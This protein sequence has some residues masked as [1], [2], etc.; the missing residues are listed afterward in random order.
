VVDGQLLTAARIVHGGTVD[1]S[2]SQT[3]IE[4]L[5]LPA[6]ARAIAEGTAAALDLAFC[7][8]DL[9]RESGSGAWHVIDCNLSPMFVAYGRLSRVDV[10]GHLADLLLARA[11]HRPDARQADVLDLVG[12]AKSLLADDPEIARLMERQKRRGSDD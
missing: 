11:G 7:G 3:G 4:V 6:S 8:M 12:E 1:S 5:D 10:A 9:M 2:E